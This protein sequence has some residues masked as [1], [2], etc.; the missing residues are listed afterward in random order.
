M[1]TSHCM[2]ESVWLRQLLADVG[3]VQDGPTSI[4]CDNQECIALAMYKTHT[5][6]P[7]QTHQC[8]I[9]LHWNETRKP[10]MCLKYFPTEDMIANVVTKP[11]TKDRHQALTKAMGL[12]AFNYS[13]SGSVRRR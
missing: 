5:P 4:I 3:Y 7:H 10:K 13:Q 2:K 11:L 8:I 1:A 9:S 12:G 6:F